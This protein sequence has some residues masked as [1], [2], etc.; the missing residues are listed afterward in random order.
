VGEATALVLDVEGEVSVLEKIFLR[1]LILFN[2]YQLFN[3]FDNN[4]LLLISIDIIE[5]SAKFVKIYEKKAQETDEIWRKGR[6][7][8]GKRVEELAQQ[9]G[10]GPLVGRRVSVEEVNEHSHR[11]RGPAEEEGHHEDNRHFQL[12]LQRKIN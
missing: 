5:F 8:D 2:I 1:I 9:R 10:N 12:Y 11:V 7:E 4:L 6:V 3:Y